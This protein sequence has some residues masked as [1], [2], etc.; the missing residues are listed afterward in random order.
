M[1]ETSR[2]LCTTRYAL[3]PCHSNSRTMC[4]IK[5]LGENKRGSSRKHRESQGRKHTSRAPPYGD[6]GGVGYRSLS[7]LTVRS[8][9]AHVTT[10]LL[11]RYIRVPVRE[12]ERKGNET[13]A[14]LGHTLWITHTSFQRFLPPGHPKTIRF[15]NPGFLPFY[16]SISCPNL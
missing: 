12:G 2:C 14:L 3:Y 11:Q 7:S 5:V 4:K 15:K 8:T 6:L 9:R 10:C 16:I 13:L 1:A